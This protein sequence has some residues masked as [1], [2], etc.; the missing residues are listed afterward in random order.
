MENENKGST[1]VVETK[2]ETS[3]GKANTL[4]NVISISNDM[5]AELFAPA[6][7][8]TKEASYEY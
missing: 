5:T 8:L 1:E 6:K 3:T 4:Y 2:D 7:A